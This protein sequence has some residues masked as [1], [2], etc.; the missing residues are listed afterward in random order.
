MGLRSARI[1]SEILSPCLKNQNKTKTKLFPWFLEVSE[2]SFLETTFPTHFS[3]FKAKP[4]NVVCPTAVQAEGLCPA[5]FSALCIEPADLKNPTLNLFHSFVQGCKGLS[6]AVKN[7]SKYWA[8]GPGWIPRPVLNLC[9]C[10]AD[11]RSSQKGQLNSRYPYE[12]LPSFC[13]FGHIKCGLG[14]LAPA[15]GSVP[16][17]QPHQIQIPRGQ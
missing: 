8:P 9:L 4:E 3:K 13:Y 7:I 6:Q 17:V 15:Q 1:H 12:S 14:M 11:S 10:L 5:H 2:L 16:A